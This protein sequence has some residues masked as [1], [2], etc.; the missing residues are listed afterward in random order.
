MNGDFDLAGFVESIRPAIEAATEEECLRELHRVFTPRRG[1][2]K[3]WRA[4]RKVSR[5]ITVIEAGPDAYRS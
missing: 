1:P 4:R 3:S 2:F 5:L